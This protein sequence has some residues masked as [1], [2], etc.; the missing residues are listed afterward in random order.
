MP[1]QTLDET[2]NR[3]CALQSYRDIEI[4]IVDDGSWDETP[5]IGN[6]GD[7]AADSTRS[8]HFSGEQR[9]RRG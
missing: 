2:S 4:L 8:A 5:T 7:A 9:R 3:A 6:H 1:P